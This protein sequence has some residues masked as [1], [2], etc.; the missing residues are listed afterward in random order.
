MS[1]YVIL[2]HIMSYYDSVKDHIEAN[3]VSEK[4]QLALTTDA[5]MKWVDKL[6]AHHLLKYYNP[7]ID[8]DAT[9]WIDMCN[10]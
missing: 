7:I 10:C 1:Y 9:K 8:I 5:I 2:C 4:K 6:D 3:D